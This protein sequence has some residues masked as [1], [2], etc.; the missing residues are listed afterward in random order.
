MSPMKI[1]RMV[2][3]LPLVLWCF[4]P[5]VVDA[6]FRQSTWVEKSHNASS[7]GGGKKATKPL[8]RPADTGIRED[9]G[10]KY[11]KRYQEWKT[12]FLSTSAGR[13]EWEAYERSDRF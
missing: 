9:I 8:P 3:F 10:D 13:A 11:K 4:G 12:E 2:C 5:L 6:H 1:S 7:R